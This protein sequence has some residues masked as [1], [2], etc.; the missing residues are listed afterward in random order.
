[1]QFVLYINEISGRIILYAYVCSTLPAGE[2]NTIISHIMVP[3][4]TKSIIAETQSR[5][6]DIVA[7]MQRNLSKLL[8]CMCHRAILHSVSYSYSCYHLSHTQSTLLVQGL[9]ANPHVSMCF[10][11]YPH[12]T[13]TSMSLSLSLSHTHTGDNG[14]RSCRN[15]LHFQVRENQS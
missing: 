1:M 15:S 9:C 4:P 2:V 13:H 3:N 5:V 11:T 8:V 12:Y 6:A 7:E 14:R 10:P